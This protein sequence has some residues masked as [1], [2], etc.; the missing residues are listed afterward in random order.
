MIND[1]VALPPDHYTPAYG[2]EEGAVA[3]Q[4]MIMGPD[5]FIVS[6]MRCEL[7]SIQ[8]LFYNQNHG[9]HFILRQFCHYHPKIPVITLYYMETD[10]TVHCKTKENMLCFSGPTGG[11]VY[12]ATVYGLFNKG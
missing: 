12:A 2:L 11:S 1:S 5:D 3:S 10:M 7:T 6:V 9:S 4:V 8:D